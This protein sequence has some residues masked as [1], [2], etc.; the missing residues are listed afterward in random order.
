MTSESFT[1]QIEGDLLDRLDIWRKKEIE[2][3][4]R[5][6]AVRRLLD[7]RFTQD[8]V[9]GSSAPPKEAELLAFYARMLVDAGPESN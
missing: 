5:E 6:D 3:P 4:S 8:N 1:L 2:I 9:G 7:E